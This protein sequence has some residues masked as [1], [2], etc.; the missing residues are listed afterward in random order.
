MMEP[1]VTLSD[2]LLMVECTAF[3]C[4]CAR[5][6]ATARGWWSLFYAALAVAAGAG[7]TAHGFYPT[8]GEQIHETLWTMT[9]LAIGATALA[10][11]G[12][13]AAI[14]GWRG[15]WLLAVYAVPHAAY[16]AA[17]LA[18][19]HQFRIAIV[20]YLPPTLALLA[21]FLRRWRCDRQRRHLVGAIGVALT[22]VAAAI[23]VSGIDL[24]PRWFD[25]NAF[26]HVVQ[27]SAL[28]CLMPAALARPRAA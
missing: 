12:I 24:D 21:C 22:L 15:R 20:C 8:D 14:A 1:G 7:G 5:A 27:A 3:C 17:V 19:V 23:Q 4:W 13:A 11:W 25:H 9:L 10:M 18:G 2:Y 26:Y 28:A 6:G 16:A